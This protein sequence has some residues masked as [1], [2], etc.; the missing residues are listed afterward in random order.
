M[1]LVYTEEDHGQAC[2]RAD[3]VAIFGEAIVGGPSRNNCI[4]KDPLQTRPPLLRRL[5]RAM[6]SR[7]WRHFGTIM[8]VAALVIELWR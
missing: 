8:L 3:L 2:S 5:R 4:G 1:Y 7:R 6:L